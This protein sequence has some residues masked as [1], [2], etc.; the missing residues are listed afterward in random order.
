MVVWKRDLLYNIKYQVVKKSRNRRTFTY[1]NQI[2]IK[3]NV[4]MI[5][6]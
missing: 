6:H 1:E 2:A 5:K 3:I 4:N